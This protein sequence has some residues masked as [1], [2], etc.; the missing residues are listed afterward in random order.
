[1]SAARS[2]LLKMTMG[3]CH[4]LPSSPSFLQISQKNPEAVMTSPG[5]S[6]ERWDMFAVCECDYSERVYRMW[7]SH[8][9]CAASKIATTIDICCSAG[10]EAPRPP[11]AP[12]Y[13][14]HVLHSRIFAHHYTPNYSQFTK[15]HG[16]SG[17]VCCLLWHQKMPNRALDVSAL[18]LCLCG[19]HKNTEVTT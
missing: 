12:A 19:R 1:M 4:V 5:D 8:T 11:D 17:Y 15:N 7:R 10:A 3:R 2:V 18:L 9:A 16:R 13:K 6:K 14:S